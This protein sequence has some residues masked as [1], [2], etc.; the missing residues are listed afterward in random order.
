MTLDMARCKS[1][2]LEKALFV[3]RFCTSLT[4]THYPWL[5]APF[6]LCST[7]FLVMRSPS[8]PNDLGEKISNQWLSRNGMCTVCRLSL[9]SDY[10]IYYNLKLAVIPNSIVKGSNWAYVAEYL[11]SQG[12]ESRSLTNDVHHPSS[13]VKRGH[14]PRSSWPLL[15]LPCCTGW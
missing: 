3:C 5:L 12:F 4:R 7:V 6:L 10:L 13:E 15:F 9:F 14:M 2:T 8:T 1:P 11:S